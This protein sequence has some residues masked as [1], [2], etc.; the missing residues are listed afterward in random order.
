MRTETI[1]CD[2]CKRDI[3]ESENRPDYRLALLSE[4][5]EATSASSFDLLAVDPVP[6]PLHFCGFGCL[7]SYVTKKAH[8]S[9]VA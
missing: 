5:M 2:E 9:Q 8:Y 1:T 6:E 3:T 7:T 4:R